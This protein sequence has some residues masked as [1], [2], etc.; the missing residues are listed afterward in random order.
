[1]VDWR[2]V[3]SMGAVKLPPFENVVVVDSEMVMLS[4]VI[5]VVVVAAKVMGVP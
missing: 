1:M 2:T 3:P 4:L 5:V